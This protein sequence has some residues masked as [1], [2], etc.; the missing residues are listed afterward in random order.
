MSNAGGIKVLRLLYIEPGVDERASTTVLESYL[1]SAVSGAGA[2]PPSHIWACTVV[3]NAFLGLEATEHTA[4][5]AIIVK[6]KMEDLGGLGLLEIL[7]AISST[8]PV[9]AL[10]DD[11]EYEH[12]LQRNIKNSNASLELMKNLRKQGFLGVLHKPFSSRTLVALAEFILKLK[13]N[14]T[15]T[16]STSQVAQSSSPAIVGQTPTTAQTQPQAQA[17][18]QAQTRSPQPQSTQSKPPPPQHQAVKDNASTTTTNTVDDAE[19]AAQTTT[20]A[21]EGKE[22]EGGANAAKR[23]RID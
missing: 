9:V 22:D 12:N 3:S 20:A 8:T 6:Y 1:N 5:D 16:T 18:A 17:Q 10:V 15:T 13:R 21:A 23:P 11:P 2:A 14:K 4:F 19:G 7:R